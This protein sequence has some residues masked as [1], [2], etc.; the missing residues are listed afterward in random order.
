MPF[1]GAAAAGLGGL[2]KAGATGAAKAGKAGL[3]FLG[4]QFGQPMLQAGV[5]AV[6]QPELEPLPGDPN[7]PLQG[8]V[9]KGPSWLK[10]VMKGQAEGLLTDWRQNLTGHNPNFGQQAI[11]NAMVQQA[12]L[13]PINLNRQQQAS[14]APAPYQRRPGVQRGF[15]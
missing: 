11:A 12:M 10:D 9:Q 5:Q 4:K 6:G 3:N 14:I 8:S 15:Y 2:L 13:Q 1:L 7:M